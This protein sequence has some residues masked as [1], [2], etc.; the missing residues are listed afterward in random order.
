LR[1]KA[2]RC[3]ERR[4]SS[5]QRIADRQPE[6]LTA[7]WH[8]PQSGACTATFAILLPRDSLPVRWIV[9]D[10]EWPAPLCEPHWLGHRNGIALPAC[11]T[12]V[13]AHPVQDGFALNRLWGGALN[14][15]FDD[16]YRLIVSEHAGLDIRIEPEGRE[17]HPLACRPGTVPRIAG[18]EID[19]GAIDA[20]ASMLAGSGAPH[21]RPTASDIV[22][23]VDPSGFAVHFADRMGK[24]FEALNQIRRMRALEQI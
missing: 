24:T 15:T 9:W 11:C 3:S 21:E 10:L 4:R 6:S 7:R 1:C 19:P 18:L 12:I 17:G 16:S 22:A 14:E 5:A 8:L 2:D 13:S 23:P 20:V